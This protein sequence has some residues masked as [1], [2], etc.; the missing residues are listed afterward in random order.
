MDVPTYVEY[1]ACDLGVVGKDIICE[2]EPDT[3]EFM[4]LGFVIADCVSLRLKK[5]LNIPTILK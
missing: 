3:F 1:G 5:I 2:V 4:D